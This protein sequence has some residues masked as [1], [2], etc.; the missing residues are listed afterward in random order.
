M[1]FDA[2]TRK[3]ETH[4]TLCEA[5]CKDGSECLNKAKYASFCRLHAQQEVQEK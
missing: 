4:L 5:T 3:N 1:I 2:I